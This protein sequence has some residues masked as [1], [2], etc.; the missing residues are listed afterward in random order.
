MAYITAA[1]VAWLPA[2]PCWQHLP[3]HIWHGYNGL[4]NNTGQ[5]V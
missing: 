3:C 5:P 1:A 4:Y 2:M